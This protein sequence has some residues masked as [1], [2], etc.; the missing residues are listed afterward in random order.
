[1]TATVYTKAEIDKLLAAAANID[2]QQGATL[3]DLGARLARLEQPLPPPPP[4]DANVKWRDSI[5]SANNVAEC[6]FDHQKTECPIGTL[7]SPSD[8]NGANVSLVADPA[9]G[10][11]KAL[12]LYTRLAGLG[13]RAQV[14]LIGGNN[15]EFNKQA[16]S[17][18][19]IWVAW[20]AFYPVAIGAGGDPDPWLDFHG[21][22]TLDAGQGNR[23]AT[24]PGLHVHED[25]SMRVHYAWNTIAQASGNES[26]W[27]A[28]PFSLGAWC[29][30]ESYR[31]HSA[32]RDAA[33]RLWINR[34]LVLEQTGMQTATAV[35]VNGNVECYFNL[36]GA[37]NDPVSK[38]APD[39][40]WYFLRNF[41]WG[42]G[43]LT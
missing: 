28:K 16:K 7:V 18:E 33:V 34:E 11:G 32:S 1:M 42:N 15:L 24:S 3:L 6:G 8:A 10:P 31:R 25:G 41:R 2:A 17:A 26:A 14:G 39:P 13:G 27:S 43:R 37:Q 23:L 21:W 30:V 38:W 22:H 12:R 5:Q 35:T 20:E 9:G 4:S 19:G 36:Y 29:T 40:Y